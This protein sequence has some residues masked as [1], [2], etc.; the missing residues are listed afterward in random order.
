MRLAPGLAS[1]GAGCHR[2][3]RQD[4]PYPPRVRYRNLT[5]KGNVMLK[6]V[7]IANRGEI[8]VRVL[9]ACGELGKS[10]M[11]AER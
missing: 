9:R 11:P 1:T 7:L 10:K 3:G 2:Q 6:K 4:R 5:Y 8:A